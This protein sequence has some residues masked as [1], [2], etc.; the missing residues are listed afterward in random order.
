[1]PVKVKICGITNLE[2]ALVALEAGADALGLVFYERSPRGVSTEVAT[3][4]ITYLPPG[5][6]TIGV[7]VDTVI[8]TVLSVAERCGLQGLQFHGNETPEYCAGFDGHFAI[9]KAF[10]VRDEA[11][12]DRLP[13][14]LTR[15]W[16]L[17]A[18]SP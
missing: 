4:I 9:M 6:L 18:W 17:D 16:L 3:E 1:M 15:H 2:D 12:L 10:Q 7:F 13:K 11:S 5:T 8:E 14:Y